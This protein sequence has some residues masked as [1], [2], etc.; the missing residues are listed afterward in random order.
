MDHPK[1]TAS[2]IG[3]KGGKSRSARKLLAL[4]KNLA[5]A[6]AARSENLREN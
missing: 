1:V 4:S 5:K 3:S 2:E 6:K